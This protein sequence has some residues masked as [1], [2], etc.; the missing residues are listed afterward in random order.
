MEC[1]K[2]VGVKRLEV[3]K[4]LK[5]QTMVLDK[6]DACSGWFTGEVAD[7]ELISGIVNLLHK[8]H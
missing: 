3:N 4:Y 1:Q 6:R 2:T 5:R 8:H 7:A